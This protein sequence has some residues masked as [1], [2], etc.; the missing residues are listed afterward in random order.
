MPVYA[1][2]L[3]RCSKTGLREVLERVR[4]VEGV[5]SAAP[6]TGRFDAV[7]EVEAEDLKKLAVLVMEKIQAIEGVERT[8]TLVAMG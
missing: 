3:L 1:Y 5:K 8:E 7:V 6:V 4:S 2:I